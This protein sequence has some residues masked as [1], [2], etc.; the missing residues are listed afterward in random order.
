MIVV[1]GSI[2][3][4]LVTNVSHIPSPGETVLCEGYFMVPGAKG[5][6]QALAAARAGS[7]VAFVA[8]CGDDGFAPLAVSMLKE[9]GVDLSHL[10]TVARPTA[11][12]LITVDAAAENAIVVASGAN[13]LTTVRQLE[14]VTLGKGDTL[15]LQNEIPPNETFAAVALARARG[16]RSV[17]NVAPAGA[18]PEETLLALDVLIVNEH[19]AAVVAKAVGIVTDDPEEAVRQINARYGC[20]TIVTLGP[21]GAVGWVDGIRRA[22]PALAVKPVD[23]TAAGDSFTGAFAAALDQGMGFTL[24]LARGAAAGSL[25]CTKPGAQPS[26]PAKSEIDA[27]TSGFAA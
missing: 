25:A 14:S 4:D 18:V 3:V 9:A 11:V 6:N 16:A 15:V 24:A 26:I 17:L 21:L 7:R 8:S 10:A 23:T 20:A 12:A 22:V 1:F 13:R 27:A 19:E 5:G 2:G